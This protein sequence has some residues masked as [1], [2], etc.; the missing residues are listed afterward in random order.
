MTNT[1][2]LPNNPEC[3]YV[4]DQIVTSQLTMCSPGP[5]QGTY[6]TIETAK[7]LYIALGKVHFIIQDY[8][9]GY[10]PFTL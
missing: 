7:T 1:A 2:G 8:D 6:V 5:L 4:A 3:G 9:Q 10:N